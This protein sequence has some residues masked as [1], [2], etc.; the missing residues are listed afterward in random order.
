MI[1][2]WRPTSAYHVVVRD[3]VV[4]I[5]LGHELIIVLQFEEI[6]VHRKIVRY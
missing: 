2:E 3:K 5:T 1:Q 4:G 6:T